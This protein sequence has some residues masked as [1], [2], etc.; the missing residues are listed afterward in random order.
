MTWIRRLAPGMPDLVFGIVLVMVTVGCRTSLLNDPGTFWH[1]RLGREILRTGDVPRFDTLTYTRELTPWVDQSWAFDLALAAFVDR[2][3]WSAAIAA[4]ALALATLYGSLARGLMRDGI[5]PLIATVVTILAAGIGSIHFLIR[6]HLFT[7]LFVFWV[8]RLCQRQHERSDKAVLLVPFLMVPWANLHGGFL[9]GP[10]IVLTATFGHAISGPWDASRKRNLWKFAA[11]FVLCLLAPLINPY[12]IGL[13]QHVFHLLGS[14]GVTQLIAEYQPIPFGRPEFRLIE[15]VI[16]ALI[17]LPTF[18]TRRLDRYDLAHG[19]VWL[20]FALGSVRHAPLFALVIAPGLSKLLEGLPL[21]AREFGQG[22]VRWTLWP[23]ATAAGM[24]LA[25][26]CGIGFGGFDPKT[27]PLDGVAVL[28]QQPVESR[29]FHE[30]D[31]GGM[32][33]AECRPIRRAFVDDR[34]ELFGKKALLNYFDAL[35]GGPDWDGLCQ[36]ERFHLVWVKPDRGLAKRLANDPQWQTLH[37]DSVS[38][39]FGRKDDEPRL[40]VSNRDEEGSRVLGDP[41]G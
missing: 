18:S 2:W 33:E 11:A 22:R 8:L 23:L 12:G 5:P 15:W 31:W 40:R 13:Y 28:N 41:P 39:L 27:W 14:S 16:L 4:T 32:I 24:G 3:G 21:A 20:H 10:L 35:Q 6:P 38:V 37:R 36:Q 9:A 7:L 34:F 30:Q 26:W 29:L 1:V 19:L 25:L 17:A